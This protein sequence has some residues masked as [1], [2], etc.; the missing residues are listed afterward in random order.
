MAMNFMLITGLN[1]GPG[2]VVDSENFGVPKGYRTVISG[3]P[4]FAPGTGLGVPSVLA[5]LETVTDEM[6]EE[7]GGPYGPRVHRDFIEYLRGLPDGTAL[8]FDD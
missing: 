6:M 5:Y 4:E 8:L 3:M 7:I 2:D 1:D